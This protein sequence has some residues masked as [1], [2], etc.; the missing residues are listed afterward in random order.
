MPSL[1]LSTYFYLHPSTCPRQ[2]FPIFSLF[3]HSSFLK[4]VWFLLFLFKLRIFGHIRSLMF[5]HFILFLSLSFIIIDIFFF[6]F[7]VS[8]KIICNKT[9]WRFFLFRKIH[10]SVGCNKAFFNVL[11]GQKNDIF[12]FFFWNYVLTYW[13]EE[14]YGR[15]I[16]WNVL[17]TTKDEWFH[18]FDTE[19][20]WSWKI[21]WKCRNELKIC[22][23]RGRESE[24][25]VIVMFLGMNTDCSYH[26]AKGRVRSC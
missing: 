10:L 25:E 14:V 9:F 18:H 20:G 23:R 17:I 1:H 4:S 12:F 26:N 24:K 7:F 11:G 22:T 15:K 16:I 8:L 21:Y 3:L 2:F 13:N 5:L 19:K 6:L